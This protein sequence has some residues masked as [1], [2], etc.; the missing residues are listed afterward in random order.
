MEFDDEWER[1]L[2]AGLEE[3]RQQWRIPVPEIFHVFYCDVIHL[4]C[5]GCHEKL[6]LFRNS[7]GRDYGDLRTG[8]LLQQETIGL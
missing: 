7:N 1:T 6:L 8:T 4:G 5:S 3:P 2:A